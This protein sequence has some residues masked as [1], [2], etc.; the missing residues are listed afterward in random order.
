MTHFLTIRT[1][2]ALAG[3]ALSAGGATAQAPRARP[4][5]PAPAV[6]APPVLRPAPDLA[7]SP[8]THRP[9]P[10]ASSAVVSRSPSALLPPPAAGPRPD[11]VAPRRGP[12]VLV[13]P[14]PLVRAAPTP[15]RVREF[16]LVRNDVAREA[17]PA[18]ATGRCK[19]GTF[20][21]APPSEEACSGKGG[22]A[23]RLPRA[24]I[25]PPRRP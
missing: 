4:L 24:P 7:P 6:V 21:V 8:A 19:D 17:P 16:G 13:T 2:A 15:Q 18:G 11:S 25:A 20:L 14:T 3:V 10:R 12:I 9:L 22:L 5:P 23:V 1:L